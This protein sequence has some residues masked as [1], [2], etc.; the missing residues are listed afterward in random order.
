MWDDATTWSTF[1]RRRPRRCYATIPAVYWVS[2]RIRAE[3]EICCDDLAVA[4]YGDSLSYARA[5]TELEGLCGKATP[6]AVAAT[7]G[8][9]LE[10]VRRIVG[11]VG[12]RESIHCRWVAGLF[13]IGVLTLLALGPYMGVRASETEGRPSEHAVEL[14]AGADPARPE[15]QPSDLS[16]QA[17]LPDGASAAVSAPVAARGADRAALEASGHEELDRL[18]RQLKDEDWWMRQAAAEALGS[19]G[20]SAAVEPLLTALNDDHPEARRYA[21]RALG[22]IGDARAVGAISRLLGDEE[23]WVRVAA[24]RV[25]GEIGDSKAVRPLSQQLASQDEKLCEAAAKS[26]GKIGGAASAAVLRGALESEHAGVRRASATA[27][28]DL[29]DAGAVPGLIGALSDEE[30][31]V[32][33]RA[34]IALGQ[35]GDSRAAAPLLAL[36]TDPLATTPANKA[37]RVRAAAASALV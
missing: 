33:V 4:V 19:M 3:R 23:Q 11:V 27:L 30:Y 29:H 25:L 7:D 26:L 24:A 12:P 1:S 32:R 28:G 34:A 6:V 14:R 16:I 13:A 22:Q 17:L 36:L 15:A 35:I 2:H 18:I 37:W 31:R 20:G 10:R 9:L 5:L 8:F 21:V